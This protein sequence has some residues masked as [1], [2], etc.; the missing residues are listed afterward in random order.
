MN[1]WMSKGQ[2]IPAPYI[3]IHCTSPLAN[4]P[5]FLAILVALQSF[6]SCSV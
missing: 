3:A 6:I 1:E 2:A 4:L 5:N